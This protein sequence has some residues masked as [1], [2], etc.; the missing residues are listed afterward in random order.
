MTEFDRGMAGTARKTIW[1]FA[2]KEKLKQRIPPL[3]TL[4]G[5]FRY[6]NWCAKRKQ[7]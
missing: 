6:A 1:D 4:S 3:R 2:K 5:S 7:C